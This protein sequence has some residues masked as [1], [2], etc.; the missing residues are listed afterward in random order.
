MSNVSVQTNNL[1]RGFDE[2]FIHIKHW[3]EWQEVFNKEPA[4]PCHVRRNVCYGCNETPCNVCNGT[5]IVF[6]STVTQQM[7]DAIKSLNDSN[8]LHYDSAAMKQLLTL[9]NADNKPYQSESES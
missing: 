1:E 9:R 6:I 7:T 4:T 8:V 2:S 3:V 5:P